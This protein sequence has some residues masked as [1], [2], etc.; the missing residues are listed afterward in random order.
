M[1]SL[2]LSLSLSLNSCISLNE[3]EF[4]KILMKHDAPVCT[5]CSRARVSPQYCVRRPR[6]P[7]PFDPKILPIRQPAQSPCDSTSGTGNPPTPTQTLGRTHL[8][9]PPLAPASGRLRCGRCSR[10]ARWRWRW[11]RRLTRRRAELR[12]RRRGRCGGYRTAT[13]CGTAWR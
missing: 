10:R 5:S 13:G 9:S 2:S 1:L 4:K 6:P 8:P 12:R 7:L 3:V 11:R